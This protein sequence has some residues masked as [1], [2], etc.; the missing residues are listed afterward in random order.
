A[1]A[2]RPDCLRGRGDV[3]DGPQL[4]ADREQRHADA[5][6]ELKT[7]LAVMRAQVDAMPP[8]P[9]VDALRGDVDGMSRL[10]A[11]LLRLADADQLAVPPDAA[12][13]L[14]EVVREVTGALGP[15]ALARGRALALDAP[16]APILVRGLKGPLAQAVRNLVENAL[17]HAPAGTTVA[18]AIDPAC[19]LCVDDEGP[20]IAEADRPHIFKRFWRRD[21]NAGDGA[22]LGLSIAAKIVEA[23]GGTLAVEAPTG[24]GTRFVMALAPAAAD[25]TRKEVTP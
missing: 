12:C 14:A 21:R 11:Q 9:Q 2:V 6:H 23:H 25:A 3:L 16:D 18:L 1:R 5:A 24:G 7:P 8:G 13:D 20:G 22:G 10:V 19:R 17:K 4:G 15:L